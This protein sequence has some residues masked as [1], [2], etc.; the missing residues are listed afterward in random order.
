MVLGMIGA[1]ALGADA[2]D[3]PAVAA[4]RLVKPLIVTQRPAGMDAKKQSPTAGGMLR[5]PYGEKA[6]LVLILP[7]G[8]KRRLCEGFHSACEADVSFDAKRILFAGKKTAAD[9]W[10]IYETAIDGGGGRQITDGI[11]DCRSPVYQSTLYT[12]V[13]TKPWRQ[14][15]FVGAGRGTVN[16]HGSAAN[17]NLYSCK[18]D[19]SALRRL[20][21]NLSNDMDPFLM[22][23]GRLLLASWQRSTLRRGNLGRVA[24]F[25]INL[26]GTDYALFAGQQQRRIRH[27]PCVT[28]GGLA[29]FVEAD[30]LTW[31]GAGR[32]ACVSMRRPLHS[33]RQ[34]TSEEDGLYHTPSPFADGSILVSRRPRDGSGTHGVY[35]LDPTSGESERIFDDPRY[36]EI[37]AKLID[38]RPEPD[39]RSSVVTEKD[40]QGK[41]YCL[42]V[43]ISDLKD[44]RQMPR[45]TV[46]RIRVLEGMP[47]PA[48][49]SPKRA[50]A[51][52][53]SPLVPRRILGEIDVAADGSFN[54]A[55]PANTPIELQALDARGMALRTCSWIW[56]KNHE[57]R[58][59]VGCHEDGEL[60]PE[61]L[62][63][64]A[65]KGPSTEFCPPPDRRRV[66]DFR[67]HVMPIIERKCIP[68][69]DA[70]GA[71]PRLDGD[72][73]ILGKH[74]QPGSART[75]PLIWHIFGRNTSRA[76]DGPVAKKPSVPIP[77]GKV[78]PL[79]EEEKRTFIEWIDLGATWDRLPACQA[80]KMPTPRATIGE[81][82]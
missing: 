1:C 12:I 72:S 45:G 77:P 49:P 51:T 76:W 11:G 47:P 58:G 18:L 69:H 15:T 48:G 6:S 53:I 60:T 2:G 70:D 25:G 81:T 67:R 7:D 26:D 43:N 39:G 35:R 56:A 40:P 65:F 20:T 71:P 75:S 66:V 34:I 24:L 74:V 79:N 64:D 37:Q 42:N 9:D 41:L 4:A 54:V 16:E 46:K 44:R 14:I 78:Q 13:S 27:M 80:G 10:N 30:Q 31:D 61:N 21:F 52:G 68:C 19:G 55:V 17:T 32:L 28:T 57:P 62:F 38:S 33:Y 8:A 23:D 22:S 36:H 63:M 3:E 73:S 59:C 29:V 50:Y 5:A 82:K